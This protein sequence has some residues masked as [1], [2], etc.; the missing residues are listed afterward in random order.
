MSF[1]NA[2]QIK[3][4]V[5]RITSDEGVYCELFIGTEKALLLDTGYGLGDLKG[6][7]EDLT[8]K[9]ITIVNTHGHYD[10]I[11]GNGQFSCPA[12]MHENDFA[13]AEE[14]LGE[15]IRR[16]CLEDAKCHQDWAW[17]EP[18]NI[19]PPGFDENA[20]LSP[21]KAD[22]LPVRENDLLDIGGKTFQVI[23]VPGHT[24]GSIALL[25]KEEGWCYLGDSMN[26]FLFLFGEESA[27]ISTYRQSVKKI[28]RLSA[29]RLY[30]SHSPAVLTG[31]DL[32]IFLETAEHI[33]YEAGAP[34]QHILSKNG[35]ARLCVRPGYSMEDMGKPGF[36][37]MVVS[38]R[39]L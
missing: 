23:E 21:G 2:Q 37:A 35:D 28:K 34:F 16:H 26:P 1:Y 27:P 7:I 13:L 17:P 18:K 3:D 10:H 29:S 22:F 39:T 38:P 25:Y 19:L 20:Y 30:A 32:D 15:A 33:D 9:P 12:Y 11:G 24:R 5:Y 6:F 36:A 8:D 31:D 4:S 14:H